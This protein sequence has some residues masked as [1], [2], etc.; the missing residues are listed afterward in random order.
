[1]RSLA[2]DLGAESGRAILGILEGGKL[3]LQELH[4]FANQPV[5]LRGNFHWNTLGLWHELKEGLRRAVREVP[6]LTSLGIDTWGVDFG[7]LDKEGK[8]LG[9]PF[10]YRDP[11]NDLGFEKAS[12]E[13]G[14]ELIW[15]ETGIQTLPINTIFQLRTLQ[16]L[17]N[18]S[19]ALAETLLF[20]PDLLTYFFTGQKVSELTVASTSSLL[21]A[22]GATWAV[23]L[24]EKLGLKSSLF[25]ELKAPG[26]AIGPLTDEMISEVGGGEKLTVVL[27]AEH[28][29]ASAVAAVP[30]EVDDFAYLSSGTWSL[31]GVEC[32]APV[33]TEEARRGGLTNERGVGGKVRL[34]K[35]IMGLWLLQ[36]SRRQWQREGE[37]FTYAELTELAAAAPA[38]TAMIDPD[39]PGF[40][41]PPSMPAAIGEYCRKTGQRVPETKGE[42]CRTILEGL[43]FKYRWTMERLREATGKQLPVLHIVGGGI[44]NELLC[45]FTAEATGVKVIA[46]PVEAT[47][48]GNL[49]VQAMGLG[50]LRSLEEIREVVRVSFPP[51]E[52]LPQQSGVW[53]KK[54]QEFLTLLA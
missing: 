53:E 36:Q 47:A 21:A 42:I 39:D 52:Y 37:N 14:E 33:L 26:T 50:Q 28:D 40:L 38:F 4:R 46:G 24:I 44:Q 15:Q 18:S 34:L 41:N 43:A 9:N 31:L 29:T 17:E 48:I 19:L 12:A 32:D 11:Q 35:N 23:P 3:E 2:F 30:A 8:L 16:A 7:L 49:L 51:K 27:P 20:M 54:Y 5:W 13:L 6:E 1:M 45:Q 22:D 25:A 10:H